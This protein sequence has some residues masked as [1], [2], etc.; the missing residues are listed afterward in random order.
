MISAV[1]V[2][3]LTGGGLVQ[4]A[5]TAISGS[6]GEWITVKDSDVLVERSDAP[7]PDVRYL[8]T[9]PHHALLYAEQTLITKGTPGVYPA[10]G[11]WVERQGT[12]NQSIGKGVGW[13]FYPITPGVPTSVYFSVGAYNIHFVQWGQPIYPPP[14]Y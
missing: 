11:A 7:L 4:S 8:T 9:A 12:K 6:R 14:S 2:V 10:L 3:L 13:W 5:H 1:S